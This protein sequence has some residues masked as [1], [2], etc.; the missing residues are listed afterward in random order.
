MVK[1][2]DP[3]TDNYVVTGGSF[4][5]TYAIQERAICENPDAGPDG[6]GFRDDGAA[7]SLEARSV[8]QAVAFQHKASATQSMNPSDVCPSLDVGKSDGLAVCGFPAGQ[9]A[10]A[11][12]LAY[13]PEQSPTLRGASSGTNQVPALSS[14]MAVRR[15]TPRECE[16]LQGLPDGYTEIPKYNSN[17]TGEYGGNHGVADGPRYRAL[18]NSMA[19]PVMAHIGKRIQMVEDYDSRSC[20]TGS[21]RNAER[22]RLRWP[23]S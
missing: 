5:P 16:R 18:G 7:Y 6:A 3:T 4:D 21:D 19:V 13:Q 17:R 10:E 9:S 11:G 8:P 23:R 20:S 1:G 14:G 15:L 12:S 22:G 2:G